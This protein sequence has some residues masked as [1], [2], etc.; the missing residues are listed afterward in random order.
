MVLCEKCWLGGLNFTKFRSEFHS[1]ME[2]FN[3]S[4][5]KAFQSGS[6]HPPSLEF[7]GK[8][9]KQPVGLVGILE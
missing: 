6:L 9:L 3:F 4:Y 8:E 7:F 5:I 2:S 1:F